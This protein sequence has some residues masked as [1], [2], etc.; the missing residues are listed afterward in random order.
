MA[1]S[2]LVIGCGAFRL[3]GPDLPVVMCLAFLGCTCV[4]L[5]LCFVEVGC[6]GVIVTGSFRLRALFALGVGISLETSSSSCVDDDAVDGDGDDGDGFCSA[7]AG[8]MLLLHLVSFVGALYLGLLVWQ[9]PQD[10]S[11]GVWRA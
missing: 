11:W 9:I 2:R 7:F 3:R 5:C 8:R 1:G 6:G 10:S 4:A